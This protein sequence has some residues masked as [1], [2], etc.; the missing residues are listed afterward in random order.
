MTR[1]E[2]FSM[3]DRMA[4]GIAEMFV[5]LVADIFEIENPPKEGCCII[6]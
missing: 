3:L 2:A 5:S 4:K 1:E 6:S